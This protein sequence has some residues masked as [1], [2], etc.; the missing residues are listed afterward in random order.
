VDIP[1]FAMVRPNIAAGQEPF[2]EG[3]KWLKEHGYS[4]VLHILAPG[5]NDREARRLFEDNGLRYLSLRLSPQTLSREILNQFGL[6]VTD[7]NNLPLFVYD[8]DGSLAGGLW[9]LHFR[10]VDRKSDESARAEVASL[11]FKQN[12]PGPHMTMWI[13]V[14]NLLQTLHQ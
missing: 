9:Y 8:K 13:A 14:Q 2:P 12:Q 7:A 6:L 10:L 5:E 11:G 4:A 3:I 1:Q